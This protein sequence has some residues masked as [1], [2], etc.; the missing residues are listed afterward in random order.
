MNVQRN[1]SRIFTPIYLISGV[2]FII[3]L[4]TAFY[5]KIIKMQIVLIPVLVLLLIYSAGGAGISRFS[6]I[7][8]LIALP[9]GLWLISVMKR[10]EVS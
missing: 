7:L 5:K 10:G 1:L 8:P 6:A 3:A 4:I 9:L 2:L